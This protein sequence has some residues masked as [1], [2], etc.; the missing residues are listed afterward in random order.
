MF[1]LL[2]FKLWNVHQSQIMK[3]WLY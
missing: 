3:I 2:F 1:A